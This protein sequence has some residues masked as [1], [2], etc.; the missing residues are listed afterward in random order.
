MTRFVTCGDVTYLRPGFHLAQQYSPRGY[1]LPRPV[2]RLC[3]PCRGRIL[4]GRERR[5]GA[6]EPSRPL[7]T[8]DRE[9]GDRGRRGPALTRSRA[10][11]SRRALARPAQSP[12]APR[13]PRAGPH[14]G[15]A[16][17]RPCDDRGVRG[18]R[19]ARPTI[20]QM[21]CRPRSPS[22]PGDREWRR[23]PPRRLMPCGAAARAPSE[24]GDGCQGNV[25][26][27]PSPHRDPER[28]ARPLESGGGDARSWRR[29]AV[30]Y[31]AS[32]IPSTPTSMEATLP[33]I[34]DSIRSVR[35]GCAFRKS[36]EFSRPCPSRVSP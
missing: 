8:A 5:Q 1:F 18:G 12:A 22:P 4:D 9:G 20:V 16:R 23:S 24:C 31:S 32:G 17:P 33:R 2:A 15:G 10:L 28:G 21:R 30:L 3:E 11:P 29:R 25:P 36:R 34:S 26:R 14:A 6:D 35:S 19:A 7:A 27:S 13:G